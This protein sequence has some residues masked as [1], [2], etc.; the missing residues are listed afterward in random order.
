[1]KAER[2]ILRDQANEIRQNHAERLN[3]GKCLA[4]T[5]MI[6]SDIV[7]ALR[8][9]NGHILNV[10]ESMAGSAGKNSGMA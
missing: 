8:K 6:Y 7:I 10:A 9:I 1:M 5:G 3:R 2:D 4:L